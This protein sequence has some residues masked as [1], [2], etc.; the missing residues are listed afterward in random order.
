MLYGISKFIAYPYF[1]SYIR[2]NVIGHENIPSSGGVLLTPNHISY[3]DPII[4]GV[5]VRRKIYSMA[6][7]E[8]FGNPVSEYLMKSLKAFPVRRGRIDRGALKR[9]VQLLERG[10]VLCMFPEGT[11]SQDGKI[12]EGKQGVA[13]LVLKTNVPVVPVK[14]IGS[15]RLLPDGSFFPRMGRAKIIFGRPITFD[16][17]DNRKKE[18]KRIITEKIMEDMEKLR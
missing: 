2:L 8:L 9:S 16:F 17:K 1:H 12:M 18:N 13:W 10:H 6:K 3:L 7:E 4:L 5:A 14:I 11:I 15:D